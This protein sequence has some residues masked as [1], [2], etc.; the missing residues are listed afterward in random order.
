MDRQAFLREKIFI[1]GTIL[2]FLGIG[3]IYLLVHFKKT[4][5]LRGSLFLVPG[6]GLL[7][8]PPL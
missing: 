3:W 4:E 5:D 1:V 8:Q 7:P 6:A 2:C